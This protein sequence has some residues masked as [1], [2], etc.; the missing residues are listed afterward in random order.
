[1][2]R[3]V[4]L[5]ALLLA[6]CSGEPSE[7]DMRKLVE[8]HTRRTLERQGNATFRGFDNFRKQGCVEAKPKGGP[9]ESGQHDCYYAAT[10]VP[11]PG[12]PPL[13][14]N[15]KGRFRHTDKG[16]TFEDLGAQPR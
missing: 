4:L 7:G 13:T 11:Q 16:I 6:A 1:M 8:A 14:V 3:L 9:I 12:Q 10:F 2:R 15:G 5:A